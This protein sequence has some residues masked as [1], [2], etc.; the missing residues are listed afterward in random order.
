[1]IATERWALRKVRLHRRGGENRYELKERLPL[2]AKSIRSCS[3]T[4][5]RDVTA[6]WTQEKDARRCALIDKSLHGPLT[7]CEQNDLSQLQREAECHFDEVAP[8]PM[9]VL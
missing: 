9:M 7:R 6:F 1:M 3:V 4:A 8:P 5:S 2:C